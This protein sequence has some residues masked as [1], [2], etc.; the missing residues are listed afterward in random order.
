MAEVHS[1]K[2]RE[3]YSM[4][5]VSLLG[6]A[7]SISMLTVHYLAISDYHKF[8]FTVLHVPSFYILG[9]FPCFPHKK[10]WYC[11]NFLGYCTAFGVIVA[12]RSALYSSF[13]WYI[14]FMS[15]FHYLEFLTTA[16]TNPKNLSVDSYLLNHSMEYGIAAVASWVE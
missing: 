5:S 11:A 8:L 12:K 4:M 14:I 9:L 7:M 2:N 16:L 6:Y 10:I 1:K 15:L 13:G 3:S